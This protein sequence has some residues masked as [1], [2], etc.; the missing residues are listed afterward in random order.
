MLNGPIQPGDPSKPIQDYGCC[1]LNLY[2]LLNQFKQQ[3]NQA[4]TSQ[5]FVEQI[6]RVAYHV[7]SDWKYVNCWNYHQTII[8]L[9]CSIVWMIIKLIINKCHHHHHHHHDA[10]IIAIYSFPTAGQAEKNHHSFMKN[11]S[12]QVLG[13]ELGGPKVCKHITAATRML[14]RWLSWTPTMG[15][16]TQRTYCLVVWNNL[17]VGG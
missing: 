9:L 15:Y 5:E 16:D 13:G 11:A 10:Y 8:C 3:E 4:T 14:P 17:L 12:R 2:H 7:H 6:L 1:K